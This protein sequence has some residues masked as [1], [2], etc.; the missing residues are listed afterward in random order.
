MYETLGHLEALIDTNAI[1]SLRHYVIVHA[2]VISRNGRGLLIPATGGAGKSTLVAAAS[3]SG[4]T[5]LSDEF[6]IIEPAT[7]AVWP[8]R[9]SICLKP[10]GWEIIQRRFAVSVPS[11]SAIR[12]N[13][14]LVHYLLPPQLQ[15]ADQP[16]EVTHIVLPDRQPGTMARL[17]RVT[18][19][20]ALAELARH[21]F[22]LPTHGVPGFECLVQVSQH[23]ECVSLTYD[24]IEEAVTALVRLTGQ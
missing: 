13:N 22:N 11:A 20:S 8:F 5:Y 9:K 6:A 24:D 16:C 12:S 19:G 3:L 1:V 18:F 21:S 4:F 17:G 2:G 14:T 23:A 15:P 7:S 10:G